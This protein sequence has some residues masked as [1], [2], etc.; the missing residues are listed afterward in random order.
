MVSRIKELTEDARSQS[1]IFAAMP[2][3][4]PIT[5]EKDK[6]ISEDDRDKLKEDVQE[7]TKKYEAKANELAKNR[8]AEVS[9]S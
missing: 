3:K 4:R 2:T 6:E 5:A 9:E 1:A 7:L 8:E